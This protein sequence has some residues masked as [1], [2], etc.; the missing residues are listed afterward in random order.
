MESS[1][2]ILWRLVVLGFDVQASYFEPGMSFA[3]TW[4]NGVDDYYEGNWTI[5][6][7]HCVDEFDMHEYY[8]DME[9]YKM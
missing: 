3:G 4:H 6:Q 5:F 8:Q 9:D 2:G 7:K 1:I